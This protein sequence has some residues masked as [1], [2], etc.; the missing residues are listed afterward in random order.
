MNDVESKA[1][2]VVNAL[3]ASQKIPMH[4]VQSIQLEW[5]EMLGEFFPVLKCEFY[6]EKSMWQTVMDQ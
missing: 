3:F 4:R 2:D 6:E 5:E 1:M